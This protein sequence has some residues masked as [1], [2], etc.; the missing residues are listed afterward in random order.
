M[1]ESQKGNNNKLT[2]SVK[3]M[4]AVVIPNI[5]WR[6]CTAIKVALFVPQEVSMYSRYIKDHKVELRPTDMESHTNEKTST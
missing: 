3:E 4:R 5:L 1:S 2:P 6:E